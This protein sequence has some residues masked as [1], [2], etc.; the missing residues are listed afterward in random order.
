MLTI[1]NSTAFSLVRRL[2]SIAETIIMLG[3]N[4]LRQLAI[5]VT[6]G[7]QSAKPRELY[8]SMLMRGRMCE[9]IA[10]MN[11]SRNESAYFLAGILSVLHVLLDT[12][13]GNLLRQI[14]VADI[15]K[16]AVI[17]GEGFI[18]EVLVNVCNYGEGRWDKLPI[19]ID[20]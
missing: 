2:D 11:N 12:T 15:V 4:Q 7:R 17:S 8:R 19:D 9:A 6:I 14:S 10:K 3:L 20:I 16:S 1:V 18:G 5:V 13:A